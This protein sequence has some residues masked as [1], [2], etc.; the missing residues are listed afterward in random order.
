MLSVVELAPQCCARRRFSSVDAF[1][2][3]TVTAAGAAEALLRKA[4]NV[5][6]EGLGNG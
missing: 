5:C 3:S 6:L 2:G 1:G 4:A